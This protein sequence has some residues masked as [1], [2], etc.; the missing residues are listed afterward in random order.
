M[1]TYTE[2]EKLVIQ[3][4]KTCFNYHG[5]PETE[6]NDNAT[7]ISVK[8]AANFTGMPV[9]KVKGIFGSLYK[10]GILEGWDELVGGS[11]VDSHVTNKGID[12]YY[13]LHSNQPMKGEHH[14]HHY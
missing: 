4:F 8:E 9:D 5:Y 14:E 6:K 2:G 1:N 13:K 11:G 7:V 10:K 12:V 3:S